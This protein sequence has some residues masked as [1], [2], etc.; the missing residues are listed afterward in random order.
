MFKKIIYFFQIFMLF[1]ECKKKIID[2]PEPPIPKNYD[3]ILLDWEDR[4]IPPSGT[5]GKWIY[6]IGGNREGTYFVSPNGNDSDPG[7]REKPWK[8]I[9]YATTRLSPG[10]TLVIL[11]REGN[12]RPIIAGGN[13]LAHAIDLSG[14]SYIWIENIEITHNDTLKGEGKYFR[15][16]IYICDL[17]STN[18]VL[19]NIYIHHIDEFGINIKDI[20]SLTIIGCRIEYC[21]F[22][23]VGGPKGVQGGWRNVI[24]RGCTLSYSGHYYGPGIDNNPY[25][26]PDG[27][28]VEES[29]GPLL[30]ENTI[31]MHN[32]GD[33][34][35][36][37]VK[38]TTIK[39]CIVANNSCDGVKLWGD[40]SR[41]INTLIYGK[42]DRDTTHIPWGSIVIDQVEKPN[43]TFEIINC[44][45]DDTLGIVSVMYVQTTEGYRDIPVNLKLI[46]NIFSGKG[47]NCYIG[48]G[49]ASQ[50]TAKNNLFYFP[51]S[52][53]ALQHGDNIYDSTNIGNL[54]PG[55]IYGR[56]L[57]V[58][59]AWGEIGDY[60]LRDGSP[61]IDR[62][63]SDNA[64]NIDLEGKPRPQGNGFDIGCYER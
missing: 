54:G 18:I 5:R 19:K 49:R 27:L 57:F 4:I 16:A 32:K 14:K 55:N 51:K 30:V 34:L 17:P 44:T 8:T 50:I 37:K 15:D 28:G 6:I 12:R 35:D 24:I 40:S 21:G 22:G 3:Y 36:S 59:T 41:V 64:P 25:T 11:P 60:H 53:Y 52:F 9:S 39:E 42:G 29:N 45:V 1:I 33:G 38:N 46:N 31:A 47:R 48:I 23:S 2:P 20:D 56:P 58:R 26:R 13:N 62:G 7:T 10:D 43:S 63:T 61:A